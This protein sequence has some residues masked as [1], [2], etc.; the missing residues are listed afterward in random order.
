MDTGICSLIVA[1]FL[2]AGGARAG[3]T[4]QRTHPQSSSETASG[5]PVERAA[6]RSEFRAK[7][8]FKKLK[9]GCLTLDDEA[10]RVT[11]ARH[12]AWS[13]TSR[14][15]DH[16]DVI[17]V[18]WSRKAER[19]M[20]EGH[21]I[22]ASSHN[23]C[24]RVSARHPTRR[25]SCCWFEFLAFAAVDMKTLKTATDATFAALDRL[26]AH[27]AYGATGLH[28]VEVPAGVATRESGNA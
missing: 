23:L 10:S 11:I 7:R 1:T 25:L 6:T 4:R 27:D 17:V 13:I 2:I 9:A 3:S 8:G 24:H 18:R 16:G 12:A 28:T 5:H 14:R 21:S 26:L 19:H 22:A 15:S 20:I